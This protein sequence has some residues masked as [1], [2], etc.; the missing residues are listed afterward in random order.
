MRNSATPCSTCSIDLRDQIGTAFVPILYRHSTSRWLGMVRYRWR[1]QS[2]RPVRWVQG[3]ASN[4]MIEVHRQDDDG[5]QTA[6]G[7]SGFQGVRS[8]RWSGL[9]KGRNA[10]CSMGAGRA[11][12]PCGWSIGATIGGTGQGS[13]P[14]LSHCRGDATG[15]RSGHPCQDGVVLPHTSCDHLY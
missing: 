2:P 1:G 3:V 13:M 7:W 8:P 12:S 6:Q 9:H 5:I 15:A 11:K 10:L 14:C 4:P